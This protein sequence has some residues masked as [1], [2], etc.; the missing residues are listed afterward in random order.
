MKEKTFIHPYI[1]NSVPSVREEMMKEVGIRDVEELYADIPEAVRFRGLMDLPEPLLSEYELRAHTEK[2]L[3]RNTSCREV[4]NFLG[5]GCYQHY[6]PAV[7]DEIG[8]RGEFVSAYGGG[9]YADHG[10]HQA[11]FEYLSM[12]AELVDMDVVTVQYDGL[13]AISSAL[14]MAARITGRKEVLVS[15]ALSGDKKSHIHNFC[16]PSVAVKTVAFDRETGL[17]DLADLAEKIGPETA[18][19]FFETPSYFGTIETQGAEIARIAH[20]NGALCVVGTNPV[21]LGLLAPPSSFGADI[22]CGDSQPLGL[23]MNG[24]GGLCGF[25]ATGEEKKFLD[26]HPSPPLSVFPEENGDLYFGKPT[27]DTSSYHRRGDAPDFTG[28][29]STLFSITAGVYLALMGPQGMRELGETLVERAAY[30]RK[31]LAQIPGV[32]TDR[33]S[34]PSFHEFVVDLSGTGKSVGEIN[35]VLRENGIFGGKDL[36]GE[37]EGLGA[38]ALYCFTEIHSAEDIDRLARALGEAVK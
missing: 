18:C 4:L 23:H 20:E 36:S 26:E 12:M 38:C 11:L 35:A 31:R 17:T 27:N 34:A 2:M 19:V 25:I 8:S 24:G 29:L 22:T 9:Y 3:G 7:C 16:R 28:S 13:A 37:F 15:E 21:S 14:L 32:R 10:K 30:A 5:A 6:V 33:F 1:P